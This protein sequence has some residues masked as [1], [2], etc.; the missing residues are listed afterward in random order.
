MLTHKPNFALT[1]LLALAMTVGS[2][3]AAVFTWTG[4]AGGGSNWYDPLNWQGGSVP[5]LGTSYG[6]QNA[7]DVAIWDSETAVAGYIHA[8]TITPAAHWPSN[9]RMLNTELRNGTLTIGQSIN[10]G[11]NGNTFT[12]GDNDATNSATVNVNWSN[13]A[14]D[15]NGTKFYVVNSDGNL[16]VTRSITKW[17]DSSAKDAAIRIIGGTVTV[18]G[19]ITEANLTGDAG[20]YVAFEDYGSTFTFDKGTIG[21]SFG[22]ASDVSTHFGD[23]FRLAGALATDPNA[24]LQVAEDAGKF[25][26]SV[27]QIP[28]P[29]SLALVGLGG[30]MMIA[31]RR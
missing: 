7:A 21:T 5:V 19:T 1:A 13:L 16:N 27:A 23:S 8:G 11:H 6:T 25:T 29:A 3:Q 26:V 2:A 22:Q 28:E 10:W 31:R 20:D 30:L 15:P 9:S 14:R 17:S 4:G 12:I 18:S 24:L